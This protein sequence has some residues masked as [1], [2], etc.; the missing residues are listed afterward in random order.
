[1]LLKQRAGD[2]SPGQLSGGLA[3]RSLCAILVA[4]GS[5]ACGSHSNEVHGAAPR[6]DV[7]DSSSD[8]TLSSDAGHSGAGGSSTDAGHSV[9]SGQS[10]SGGMRDSGS[11]VD[12]GQLPDAAG[13][14]RDVPT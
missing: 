11:T 10:L 5:L 12:A 7:N 9:D 6:R 14:S 1:M 4:L 13:P 3:E 2:E 8:A